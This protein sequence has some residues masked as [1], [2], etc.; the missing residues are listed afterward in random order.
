MQEK[1]IGILGLGWLGEALAVALTAQSGYTVI[2][3]TRNDEKRKRLAELGI[4]GV[5]CDIYESL[6]PIDDHFANCD[7]WVINIAAGRRTLNPSRFVEAVKHLFDCGAQHRIPHI[8]FISTTAVFGSA[9]GIITEES[10]T[11]PITDSAKA[12]V[13]IEDYLSQRLP[14]GHTI[15]RLAG[16]VGADRHPA[17]YL[18]GKTGL[19]AGN[20]PVNLVHRDDVVAAVQ[21]LIEFGPLSQTRL[22]LSAT[23][24]PSRRDYYS[25]ATEQLNLTAP[26][27]E[28]NDENP[29]SL[30]RTINSEETLKRLGLALQYASPYDMLAD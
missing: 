24:H 7:C 6:A 30:G 20:E 4:Q 14:S 22:H 28:I 12:H 21:R 16:L 2:G 18:A 26:E 1:R 11:Q 3:T 10:S 27:F 23:E 17:K 13:A 19:T 15:L 9:T 29:S 5:A 25:W 8:I